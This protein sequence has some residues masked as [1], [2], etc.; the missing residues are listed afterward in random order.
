MLENILFK[1]DTN[2]S[3]F[4]EDNTGNLVWDTFVLSAGGQHVNNRMSGV[5]LTYTPTGTAV[6]VDVF[7]SQ[8]MN[9][10]LALLK[11]IIILADE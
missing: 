6:E 2:L 3:K 10:Q 7:R 4:V 1:I 11:L 5:R 9:R 8:H